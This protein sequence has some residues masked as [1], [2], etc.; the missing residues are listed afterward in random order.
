MPTVMPAIRSPV[1]HPKSMENMSWRLEKKNPRHTISCYPCEDGK[2]ANDVVGE[3]PAL[4]SGTNQEARKMSYSFSRV[5]EDRCEKVGDRNDG[6]GFLVAHEALSVAREGG[7]G[8]R[9]RSRVYSAS[10][11]DDIWI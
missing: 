11:G 8:H 10:W 7:K 1:N 4:V 9:E 6:G 5:L 3:L 2:Q